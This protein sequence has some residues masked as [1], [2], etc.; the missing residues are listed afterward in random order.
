MA[1]QE[2]EVEAAHWGIEP[3]P[4][5]HRKLSGV[6]LAVLWGD[7]GIGL[8]VIVAGALLVAPAE[9][10]GFG[11]SL[12][13]AMVAIVAGSVI[14]CALLGIGG[15]IGAQEARPTMVLLRSV[16]GVKG[17]WVP[18]VLNV[19][20]LIGWTAV[21]LWAM[22]LVADRLSRQ[23]FGFTSFAF[24]LLVFGLI[25]LGLSL[26]GPLG[27]VRI[28][29]ERF[30][31]WVIGV[32]G[33]I[34][35]GVLLFGGGFSEIWNTPGAGGSMIFGLPMDLV[36]AL[37]VSWVPLVADFNRFGRGPRSALLGTSLGYLLANI[38]FYALGALIVLRFP[39]AAVTPEGI[40][41]SVL[42]LSGITITGTLLLVGLL[43]GETDE[44]F[45]DVYSSAVSLRNIFPSIDSRILV[46]AVTA[47]GILLAGRFTMLA[48]ELFLFLLGSIFLPLLGVWFADRFVLKNAQVLEGFRWKA[49]LPWIAG[50]AVYHWIAPTPLAW[51][52][53]LVGR[54]AG[55]PL[56]HSAPWLGASIPSFL[57]AFLLHSALGSI[58]KGK[59][60]EAP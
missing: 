18:T 7:L 21:E 23:L 59:S 24:W 17:S 6:D 35:T 32:I 15:F 1:L 8:L 45:A 27:V 57:T 40:A 47:V 28:W 19:A 3:V 29:L 60:A 39:D 58:G 16:L 55:T 4:T 52:S 11:L 2:S 48:Y 44:A 12:P 9:Q 22:A 54:L 13:S 43:V 50:F 36:I 34:I 33:A 30:S 46:V 31:V 38:W 10:F 14:G 51:W 26:W 41:M 37:P 56:S 25:V 53:D 5:A 42:A 49:F 20:Q